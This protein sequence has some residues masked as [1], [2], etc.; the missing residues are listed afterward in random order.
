MVPPRAAYIVPTH[1]AESSGA[2]GSSVWIDV[3]GAR[4][5]GTIAAAPRMST[6]SS[7]ASLWYSDQYSFVIAAFGPGSWPDRYAV[8]VRRP[9][10]RMIS[11]RTWQSARRLRMI[12]SASA[13][14]AWAR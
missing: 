3:E 14:V 8:R 4:P 6:A 13:P 1:D 9:R 11:T 12:G 7:V 5:S 10:Y 2:P